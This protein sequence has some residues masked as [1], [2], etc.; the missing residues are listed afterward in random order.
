L[1]GDS[2]AGP[3]RGVGTV[4]T[5]AAT[6][7]NSDIQ[8]TDGV[9]AGEFGAE[10]DESDSTAAARTRGADLGVTFFGLTSGGGGRRITSGTKNSIEETVSSSEER[11]CDRGG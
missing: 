10:I 3:F 6:L 2:P 11:C 1:G 9:A 7:L 5:S 8:S 4:A